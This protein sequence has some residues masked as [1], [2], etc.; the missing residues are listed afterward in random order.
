MNKRKRICAVCDKEIINE[1]FKPIRTRYCS[2]VCAE[3]AM[4]K[5]Q[6]FYRKIYA[7]I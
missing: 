1:E 2:A 7:N 3:I 6:K 5:Y 4:K